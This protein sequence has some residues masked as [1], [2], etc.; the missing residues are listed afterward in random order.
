MA[1]LVGNREWAVGHRF[2]LGDIA[3]A[4]EEFDWRSLYP[5]LAAFSDRME[6][7]PSFAA[8]RPVAQTIKDR[9]I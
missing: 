8:S 9:V 2:G 4:T 3:V 5:A 1:R 7:R 6:Q